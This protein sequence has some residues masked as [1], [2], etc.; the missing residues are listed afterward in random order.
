MTERYLIA[1]DGGKDWREVTVAEFV[2]HER[3]AGFWPKGRDYG[4]PATG[5]FSSTRYPY[6]GRVEYVAAPIRTEA[7]VINET[8][9]F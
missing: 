5:G 9:P 7:Q 4:Q 3:N 2:R 6:R 1:E 8:E